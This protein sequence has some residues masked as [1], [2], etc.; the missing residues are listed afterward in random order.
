MSHHNIVDL[1]SDTVTRPTPPMREAM[2]RAEVGDD[3]F[4]DDP[5]VNR[6][7]ERVAAW[8]G[9][10][11]ALFVPSGTMANQVAIRA[12]TQPGDEIICHRTSHVY[13]Y[14]GGAPAALSGCSVALI[15]GD[16][17]MFTPADV[18]AALRAADPHFPRSRLVVLENTSNRGGGSIWPVE[19]AAAVCARAHELDLLVH[20]DGARLVNACVAAGVAP[21]AYTRHAD[22]A[23]ICFS[24][25][26]GAPVGSAVAGSAA[27]IAQAKRARKM[28]GGGMRQAGILAA[29]AEYAL[30]HHVERLADDHANAALLAELL[31]DCPHARVIAP[32]TNIVYFDVDPAWGTARALADALRRDDVW[33]IAVAAQRIRAVTHLHISAEDVTRAAE[34]VRR[35]LIEKPK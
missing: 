27:F 31:A 1:R 15:D 25:G 16:R 28:F 5:T 4:G 6:L 33:M 2:A 9:M 20:L 14:E 17:G 18:S 10:E 29:A 7:Q 34:Q 35:H 13:Q 3:V 19:Q 26:L 11:A 21:T 22:S 24:K 12:H 30:D 23:T 32:E 8:F